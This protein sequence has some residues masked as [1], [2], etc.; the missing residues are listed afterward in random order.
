M[1]AKTTLHFIIF[2][3]NLWYMFNGAFARYRSEDQN[4]EDIKF[5]FLSNFNLVVNLAGQLL[6]NVL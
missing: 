3:H 2:W 6:S 1:N 5:K 4:I